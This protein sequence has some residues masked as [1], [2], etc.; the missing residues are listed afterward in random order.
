MSLTLEQY[1]LT[2]RFHATRWNQSPFE[3][4]HGEWPPSPY[5]LLR[6]LAARWF[7]HA[8]ETGNGDEQA[9]DLLLA[10]LAKAP[11]SFH[12]PAVAGNTNQWASRGLKQYQ[13]TELVKSNKK[14]GEPWVKRHQTTLVVDGFGIVEPSRPIFWFWDELEL[15]PEQ[16]TLL[17]QLLR[18]ITYFG[19]AESLSLIRRCTNDVNPL[20]PNC[21]L[22]DK[23]G[24]GRPVLVANPTQTLDMTIFL[25]NNDDQLLRGRRIPPN[26]TWMYAKHP[27]PPR[28]T[29]R[30]SQR[31]IPP[32]STIQ[33]AV[34]GRVFPPAN[35]WVRLTDRFRGAV[36]KAIA[37]RVA[38]RREANFVELTPE[39]RAD[40]VLMTG[41]NADD[42]PLAGH[43][44]AYFWLLPDLSGNPTRLI[45]YRETP[46]SAFEQDALFTASE[47]PIAWEYGNSAWHLRL[48]PLPT[49]TPLPV[50]LFAKATDWQTV[51]P[52]IPPLHVFGRNGKPKARQSVEEQIT[53]DLAIL[54]RPE[55]SVVLSTGKALWTKIHQPARQRSRSSQTND[56]KLG[57]HVSLRFQESISGPLALGQ[58]S[59]FGL[60][61]FT[62]MV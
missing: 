54:G 51:T 23:A 21:R 9:R 18:R 40:F 25:A 32:V 48:V 39:Q 60:G 28:T 57:Y 36:L 44:H 6:S 34:G 52:Y 59:H 31:S 37:V 33:F 30:I 5:R 13:P 46:F 20:P 4:V 1:F 16:S 50:N 55:A 24:E 56:S 42:S 61:L 38:G 49:E 10:A 53:A 58:S 3:D 45:C 2:G 27:A 19:R 15:L 41:K 62:P 35:S 12:L 43:R 11:P 8:R 22:S 7:E 29:A 14:R 47:F 26:T 17:D